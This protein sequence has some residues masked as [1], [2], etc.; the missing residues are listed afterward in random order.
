[1][2]V[3]AQLVEHC[4]SSNWAQSSGDF[5]QNEVYPY[6]PS[7]ANQHWSGRFGHSTVI[8][9]D[10]NADPNV[11]NLGQVYLMGGDSDD[12]DGTEQD[13]TMGNL[14]TT[15][16]NGYK[17]DVWRMSGTEW[18]SR[19]DLRQRTHYRQKITKVM[20]RIK[21]EKIQPGLAPPV[22]TTHDDWII[23]QS[24]FSDSPYP[25]TQRQKCNGENPVQWSPRRHHASVYFKGAIY[26]MGGRAREYV[27]LLETRSVGG[28]L[29]SLQ[30][31]V[32]EVEAVAMSHFTTKREAIIYKSDVWK[33]FDGVSWKLVTPGT[34]VVTPSDL[35][36]PLPPPPS[37]PPPQ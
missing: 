30:P 11:A 26:L 20:S 21:Y 24:Y 4:A 31:R 1:M 28:V 8:A 33:S 15:W 2:L 37:P 22:G 16:N 32:R 17:N 3:F 7:P 35:L 36:S 25:S 29:Q 10:Q 14:D 18:L 27:E 23:C 13:F 34:L 12:G 9:L 5:A 19:G 6:I